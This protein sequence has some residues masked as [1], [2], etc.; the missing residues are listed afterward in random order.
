MGFARHLTQ[1][2]DTPLA[3]SHEACPHR[4]CK[5]PQTRPSRC[6]RRHYHP[7]QLRPIVCTRRPAM[8]SGTPN[9][10]PVDTPIVRRRPETQR[11]Q[12]TS[13]CRRGCALIETASPQVVRYDDIRYGVEHKLDIVRIRGTRHVTV[14]LFGR[15]LIFSFKLCLNVGG[16]LPILLATCGRTQCIVSNGFMMVCK[17][18][19]AATYRCT[20]GNR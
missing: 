16:C 7:S 17:G 10:R 20:R 9:H 12:P 19:E 18:E 14:N 5:S 4:M 1:G 8:W 11:Q 6:H 15:G 13:A 2:S 3:R